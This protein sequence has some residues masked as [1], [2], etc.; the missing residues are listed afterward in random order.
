MDAKCR[1]IIADKSDCDIFS[2]IFGD[3]LD[4]WFGPRTLGVRGFHLRAL[5]TAA[6]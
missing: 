6:Q 1:N 3:L 5:V 2:G 4:S